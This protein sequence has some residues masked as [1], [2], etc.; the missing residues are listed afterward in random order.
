MI[1]SVFYN[2]I[3]FKALWLMCILCKMKP[4]TV[5]SVPIRRIMLE[6]RRICLT[7]ARVR[8][9]LSQRE[10]ASVIGITQQAYAR[11]ER[12][13]ALPQDFKT[14]YNLESLLHVRKECLFPD[15]YG[16]ECDCSVHCKAGGG[17]SQNLT[18]AR[19]WVDQA[20]ETPVHTLRKSYKDQKRRFG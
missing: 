1:G 19:V 10:V 8:A 9:G 2:E 15:L 6:S 13:T 11:Y 16:K 18:L 3:C 12:G 14:I 4:Q 20:R 17:I 7:V 5:Q